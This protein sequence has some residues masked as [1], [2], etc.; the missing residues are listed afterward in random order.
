MNRLHWI[1][2]LLLSTTRLHKVSSAIADVEDGIEE[3][4]D[5][6]NSHYTLDDLLRLLAFDSVNS[7][8]LTVH[9]GEENL[10]VYFPAAPRQGVVSYFGELAPGFSFDKVQSIIGTE[11]LDFTLDS[12][13]I[14]GKCHEI[15]LHTRTVSS[16]TVIPDFL[17]LSNVRF[18]FLF[19][20]IPSAIVSCSMAIR[21]PAREMLE[22]AYSTFKLTRPDVV[23]SARLLKDPVR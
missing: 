7:S 15:S 10:T 17:E 23:F 8:D 18:K 16:I 3:D 5:P 4:E 21:Y 20:L 22:T 14:S 19:S 12:I 13:T 1:L 2:L 11:F 9:F 6:D